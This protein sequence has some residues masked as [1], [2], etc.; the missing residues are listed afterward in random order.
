MA[1]AWAQS[2]DLSTSD[3]LRQ[4]RGGMN[5]SYI[6]TNIGLYGPGMRVQGLTQWAQSEVVVVVD[7]L[8]QLWMKPVVGV[9]NQQRVR[10]RRRLTLSTDE[11]HKTCWGYDLGIGGLREAA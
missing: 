11:T 4:S 1:G 9:M 7:W 10:M 6:G 3:W 8:K 5:E 2:D